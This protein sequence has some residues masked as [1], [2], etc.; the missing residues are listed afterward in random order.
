MSHPS[1]SDKNK[2]GE[3]GPDA[4]AKD[5]REASPA[6]ASGDDDWNRYWEHGF[7]TSCRNAFAGNY[8]GEL[9]EVWHR[10]F[11]QLPT[12]ARVLDICTGNGAIAMIA[13]AWSRENGAGF[14][15]HGIDS[16]AIRPHETVKTDRELLDGIQ[17]HPETPAEAT[18]LADACFNAITGQYAYEYTDEGRTPAELARIAAPGALIQLVVH[19]TDSIVMETSRAELEN[20][21]LIFDET[22]IFEHARAMIEIVASVAPEARKEL[23]HNPEAERRREQLNDAAARVSDALRRSPHPQ[24]LQMTLDKVAEAFKVLPAS[25]LAAAIEHLDTSR[26]M[27]SAN[28]ERLLDLMKAGRSAEQIA[29]SLA[30]FEAAGFEMRAPE[31]I[32]HD[33]GPLMGW[34]LGGLRH[35][36]GVA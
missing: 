17:F 3:S 11:E 12:G 1:D 31:E 6:G 24:L 18:G 33:G 34:V 9:Q 16:A 23:Q 14:E 15:I 25:G 20:C 7:M 29:R 13:N 27:V 22:G 36:P 5:G 8:E 2:T 21:G 4:D 30:A 26:E 35:D 10:L 32:R 28:R 19:H